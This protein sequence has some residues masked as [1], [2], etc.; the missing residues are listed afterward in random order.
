ME[1][2]LQFKMKDNVKKKSVSLLLLF[3]LVASFSFAQNIVTSRSIT[4][5]ENL[6]CGKL[7]DVELDIAGSG[8]VS[9]PLEVVLVIDVSGSMSGDKIDDAV[10]AAE[11]FVDKFFDA[12]DH[13]VHPQ[14]K[15]GIVKFES[16]ASVV[17][18]LTNNKNAFS[19]NDFW[20]YGNNDNFDTGGGTNMEDGIEEAYGLLNGGSSA[21]NVTKT[22]IFLSDGAA[23]RSNAS[24]TCSSS[25]EAERAINEALNAQSIAQIYTIG[26]DLNVNDDATAINTLTEMQNAGF[27]I[28]ADGDDLDDIYT[29]IFNELIWVAKA[30]LVGAFDVETIEDEFEIL[31]SSVS[32]TKGSFLIDTNANT[33]DWDID[34][35][36]SGETVTL[37]YQLISNGA[38][39]DIVNVSTSSMSFLDS[40]CSS[41]SQNP[42]PVSV[43]IVCDEE[44]IVSICPGG[45]GEFTST[46]DCP[47]AGDTSSYKLEK[48]AGTGV[49][50]GD[51]DAWDTPGNITADD[52][53]SA[54]LS[55]ESGDSEYLTASNFNFS[56]IPTDA[57]ITGIS[58]VVNKWASS[59]DGTNGVKDTEVHLLKSGSAS[60]ITNK[61]N[62]ADVWSTSSGTI[63]TYGGE[64]DLWGTSWSPSDINNSSNFGVRLEANINGSRS[65]FVDYIQIKVHYYTVVSGAGDLEW[66]TVSSGGTS[67]ATG[68]TFDPIGDADVI[69]QGGDYANLANTNTPG[70]YNFYAGC[71]NLIGCRKLYQF[72]IKDDESPVIICPTVLSS[73]SADENDCTYTAVGTEFDATATD[74]CTLKSLTYVLTG[75]TTGTGESLAG[76]VFNKGITT[77]TWKASDAIAANDVNCS[78]D[79]TVTDT[80]APVITLTGAATM[81]L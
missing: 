27:F 56:S 41:V 6:G 32:V 4:V 18:S 63:V 59:S 30:P 36:K 68:A 49:T 8:D 2:T 38:C 23:T 64:T 12:T 46:I 22:I 54:V 58:V 37:S 42:N 48:Y 70:T 45:S 81:T 73:Y 35:L 17:Q 10:T 28:G 65:A 79:I 1:K 50:S 34:F 62:T 51:G 67:V 77:V 47:D 44:Q 57:T 16:S 33:I 5:G 66:Y 55:Y 72:V 61:A 75:A 31:T 78:F 7:I 74:N 21:C 69:A 25:C 60:G 52:G 76:V 13:T 11:A 39:G 43:N 40:S 20:N 24:G 26:F 15:I 80:T 3:L 9:T 71:S 29:N 19:A 14:S 53:V